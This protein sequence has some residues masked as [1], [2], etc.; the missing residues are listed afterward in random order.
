MK[1]AMLRDSALACMLCF[2]PQA[3][4]QTTEAASASASRAYLSSPA[5]GWGGKIDLSGQDRR[6]GKTYLSLASSSTT[7][8]PAGWSRSVRVVSVSRASIM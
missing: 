3:F 4:A 1:I 5:C 6:S 8:V 7:A 2:A